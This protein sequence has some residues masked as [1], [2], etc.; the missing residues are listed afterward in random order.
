MDPKRNP[1]RRV[2]DPTRFTNDFQTEFES[3]ANTEE[4]QRQDWIFGSGLRM[5]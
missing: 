1:N 4:N 2:F 5:C 3:A